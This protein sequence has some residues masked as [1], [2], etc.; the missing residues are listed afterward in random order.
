M[1]SNGYYFQNDTLFI[2]RSRHLNK[3]FQGIN[4]NLSNVKIYCII[5]LKG[6]THYDHWVFIDVYI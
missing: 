2:P 5:I 1:F 4:M 3:K 6:Q